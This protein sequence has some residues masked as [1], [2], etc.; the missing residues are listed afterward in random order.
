MKKTIQQTKAE[1]LSYLKDRCEVDDIQDTRRLLIEVSEFLPYETFF[2]KNF[3]IKKDHLLFKQ[4][5]I[6]LE[7]GLN[8]SGDLVIL[9][10]TSEKQSDVRARM[11]IFT[12]E[13][14]TSSGYFLGMS[15][16]EL[17]TLLEHLFSIYAD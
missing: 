2:G 17:K 14:P 4:N 1:I 9:L 15:S 13:F 12:H 7:I 8:K 10:D 6:W 5:G 3:R 16:Y 11:S